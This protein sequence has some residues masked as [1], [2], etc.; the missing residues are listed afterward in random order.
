M[1]YEVMFY[2]Q[3]NLK[4]VQTFDSHLTSLNANSGRARDKHIK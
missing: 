3:L 1:I 2:L 4:L